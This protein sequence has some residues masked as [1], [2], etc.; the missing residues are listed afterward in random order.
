MCR[1]FRGC[2]ILIGDIIRSLPQSPSNVDGVLYSL[3]LEPVRVVVN[4]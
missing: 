2:R 4:S 3:F 1:V